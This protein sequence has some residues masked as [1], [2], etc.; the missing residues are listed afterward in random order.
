[1]SDVSAQDRQ[2]PNLNIVAVHGIGAPE[3]GSLLAGLIEAYAAAAASPVQFISQTG[4]PAAAA[5][6]CV[7]AKGLESNGRV[8]T[9]WDANW[10]DI[11]RPP[12]N[13]TLRIPFLA[14]LLVATVAYAARHKPT[15]ENPTGLNGAAI[16]FRLLFAL[17]MLWSVLLPVLSLWSAVLVPPWAFFIL[18]LGTLVGTLFTAWKLHSVDP[19]AGIG[20][21]LWAAAMVILLPTFGTANL[22]PGAF[23][24]CGIWAQRAVPILILGCYL[25]AA[26]CGKGEATLGTHLAR[27]GL[28]ALAT[29]LVASFAAIL[30]WANL[31]LADKLAGSRPW[32]VS[33]EQFMLWN[34]AFAEALPYRLAA[35]EA[36]TTV[37]TILIGLLFVAALTVYAVLTFVFETKGSGAA[38][39]AMVRWITICIALLFP[40]A[41]FLVVLESFGQLDG[42]FAQIGNSAAIELRALGE[43]LPRLAAV[44]SGLAALAT[45]F[46]GVDSLARGSNLLE[47]YGDSA[48]R[49]LPFIGGLALNPVRVGLDVMAD[50]LLYLRDPRP[51]LQRLCDLLRALDDKDDLAIVAHSQGSRVAV[52]AIFSPELRHLKGRLATTGSPVATLYGRFLGETNLPEEGESESWI[53]RNY[54]R[55]SDFVG[56]KI[57]KCPDDRFAP[58]DE[59]IDE[60]YQL[61]HL[62]YWIEPKVMRFL[63][64]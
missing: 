34:Q 24:D 21:A 17:F 48:L 26:F 22:W 2:R 13:W 35:V 36:I 33:V 12:E 61:T 5:P 52:D 8:V 56:G 18:A 23:G 40:A 16:P 4:F 57:P 37:A 6:A 32:L 55:G 58:I 38:L 49:A 15:K 28:I 54:W 19:M 31:Y 42:R 30:I 46:A 7:S 25:V 10:S 11:E 47:I 39:R 29:A 41:V 51:Q 63:L 45:T 43:D 27:L 3:P 64:G 14:K 44:T 9:I 50:I 60:N 20:G 53:W 1:M 62:N 59:P